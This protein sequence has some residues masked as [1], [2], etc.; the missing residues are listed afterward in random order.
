M[1]LFIIF[2]VGVIVPKKLIQAE[3]R[4]KREKEKEK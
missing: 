1:I 3:Y 2:Y 4:E